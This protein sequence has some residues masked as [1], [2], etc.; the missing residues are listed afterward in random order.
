MYVNQGPLRTKVVRAV[1]ISLTG[2]E[3][4][5]VQV[6]ADQSPR[7]QNSGRNTAAAVPDDQEVER[8]TDEIPCSLLV[9]GVADIT[10]SAAAGVDPGGG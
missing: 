1:D 4:T 7:L 10:A 5:V 6:A 2:K 3:E 9:G 8:A